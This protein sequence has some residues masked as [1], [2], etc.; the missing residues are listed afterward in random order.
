MN[1]F[2]PTAVI[3]QTIVFSVG[4]QTD[5]CVLLIFISLFLQVFIHNPHARGQRTNTN[6]MVQS[7]QD[8]DISLLN[9]NQGIT[10]LTSG[11]LNPQLGYDCLL[12]GTQTNLLAYDVYNNSDLFYREAS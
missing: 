12:V 9:I 10:C 2:F 3:I 4:T 7:N 1:A 5:T 6:R 8:S 11:V